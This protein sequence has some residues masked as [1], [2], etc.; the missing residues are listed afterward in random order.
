MS[1]MVL[2]PLMSWRS[3]SSSA[4]SLGDMVCLGADRAGDRVDNVLLEW[5]LA[6]VLQEWDAS[7]LQFIFPVVLG[8]SDDRG[9][10]PFDFKVIDS[11]SDYWSPAVK[12]RLVDICIQHGIP[13]SEASLRRSVKGVVVKILENQGVLL[14]HYGLCDVADDICAERLYDKGSQA[15]I[16]YANLEVSERNRKDDKNAVKQKTVHNS[17]IPAP[18]TQKLFELKSAIIEEV[19]NQNVVLHLDVTDTRS[20]SINRGK[21]KW[22][23][24]RVFGN[25]DYSTNRYVEGEGEIQHDRYGQPIALHPGPQL[26]GTPYLTNLLNFGARVNEEAGMSY[27]ITYR[28]LARV[29]YG[30]T[31]LG[32]GNGGS[33][34]TDWRLWT[35]GNNKKKAYDVPPH[36]LTF[37][38]GRAK[39]SHWP[40]AIP[41]DATY[42]KLSTVSFSL[43]FKTG[44]RIVYING[45]R[46]LSDSCDMKDKG[47][48]TNAPEFR[49]GSFKAVKENTVGA[50]V[51][52]ILVYNL[53][54][55]EKDHE[56]IQTHLQN[57]WSFLWSQS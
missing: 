35:S 29:E 46:R 39:T 44:Q 19:T 52:E 22:C 1:S 25:D 8:D 13:I 31:L 15:L 54:L 55:N 30:E 6:L 3:A 45:E 5:E 16:N 49:I 2:A 17:A 42:G 20:I 7:L 32:V 34:G 33:A 4:G 51:G 41:E 57:K 47:N 21:L 53:A 50:D 38:T 43:N 26:V 56:R 18:P 27:A 23:D 37:G 36:S 28:K 14:S 11:L 12:R 10:F 24:T 40:T 48:G 9:Y